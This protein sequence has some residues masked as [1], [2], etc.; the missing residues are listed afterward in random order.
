[1]TISNYVQ[2][3]LLPEA[4]LGKISKTEGQNWEMCHETQPDGCWNADIRNAK[5]SRHFLARQVIFWWRAGDF[6]LASLVDPTLMLVNRADPKSPER[7]VMQRCC[8]TG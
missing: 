4:D 2:L 5:F 1:M 3:H 7:G 8:G 6:V